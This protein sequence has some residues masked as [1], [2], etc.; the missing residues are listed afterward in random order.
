MIVPNKGNKM[1]I[2]NLV[3]KRMTRDTKFMG[4]SIKISKMS[5][6]QVLEIQNYAKDASDESQEGLEVLKRIIRNSVEGADELSDDDF[7][8][9]P[10]DELNNLSK[11]IMKFSGL[12]SEAGK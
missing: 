9:F 7:L 11:E 10:M 12:D 8:N 1:G 3:G 2:Q 4:E 5:T 6:K